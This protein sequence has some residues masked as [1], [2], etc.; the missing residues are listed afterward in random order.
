M[1]NCVTHKNGG[2]I[3]VTQRPSIDITEDSTG[4]G[5]NNRARGIFYWEYNDTL[6][7]VHDND[8]Y[9]DTQD[10][11]PLTTT[12]GTFSAGSEAVSFAEAV[13]TPKLAI[14]DSENNKLWLVND[15][16]PDTLTPVTTNVPTAIVY[17][18]P[19]LDG[20]LFLMDEGGIIYNSDVDDFA[21]FGAFP[22]RKQS[23]K[24][25]RAYTLENTMIT[26]L[27]LVLVLLSFFMIIVIQ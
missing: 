27:L 25:T 8:V 1:T 4:L 2:K 26:L 11:T 7:I 12:A 10:S 13:G 5:L 14:L 23:E 21:T 6:Y 17:G 9:A 22:T 19:V 24:T 3:R 16:A 20:Y 15:A 18:S